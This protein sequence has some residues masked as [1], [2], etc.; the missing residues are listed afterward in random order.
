VTTTELYRRHL[1]VL[2]GYLTRALEQAGRHGLALTGVLCHAGRAVPYHADDEMVP[3]WATPHFRRWV[4]LP[5]P[6]HVVL[7]RPGEQPLVVEVR[8]KDFWFD[9]SPAPASYWQPAV[10]RAEV[11]SFAEVAGVLG[12]LA[13]VAYLGNSPA[14]AAE[15]GIPGEL[16]EPQALLAPLDWYRAYKTEHEVAL[17]SAA[18]RRA[19]GGHRQARAAFDAGASEREIHWSYLQGTGQLER[20]L[21]FGTITALDRKASILHYQGKRGPETAPGNVLLLDA[22]AGCD[23]YAADVT[24]TWVRPGADNAFQELVR[25]LDAVERDLVAMVTPGRPYLE[26]HLAA[27]QRVAELLIDLEIVKAGA[28]EAVERGVTRAFFP[29]GVGH[30]LGIQVHDVG[31]HQAGPE[32]G[33]VPPPAD[34][35]TLRNTR[36]VEEG[37]VVTI[38]PGIYFIPMLLEPLRQ[39]DARPLVDWPLVDHL[40]PHGGVRI[41]DNVVCTARGPRDLTRPLIEGPRG[42]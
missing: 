21:P 1:E 13:G 9:S 18:A 32:G 28:E 34:H 24:R 23:G 38:E 3:F 35:P 36:I 42:K 31:G 2:D 7:A 14:A 22:G 5:D 20:E 41:E 11:A 4:P 29:H 6:E 40:T 16:V 26:I 37:H 27:H 33:E 10:R 15:L 25:G 12:P 17:L 30:Q 39:G 19:G 8:P